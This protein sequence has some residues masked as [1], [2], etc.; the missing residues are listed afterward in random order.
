MVWKLGVPLVLRRLSLSLSY[1][2]N[3]SIFWSLQNF[4]ELHNNVCGT[5]GHVALIV[6]WFGGECHPIWGSL[7][8]KRVLFLSLTTLNAAFRSFMV[9]S[10]YKFSF[11]DFKLKLVSLRNRY[12]VTM[13]FERMK[14]LVIWNFMD[15]SGCWSRPLQPLS[16]E[17]FSLG[18]FTIP[19]KSGQ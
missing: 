19:K 2:W 14:F 18:L 5:L 17:L 1:G 8:H 16:V 15:G 3:H 7:L 12:L 13:F 10:S 11:T 4:P 9:V 6:A